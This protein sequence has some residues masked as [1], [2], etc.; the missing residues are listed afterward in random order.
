M[1]TEDYENKL[2]DRI[3]ELRMQRGVAEYRMSLELGKSG[4]YIRNITSGTAMPSVR[5]LF[6]I[7]EYLGITPAEFFAPFAEEESEYEKTVE[8][9]RSV[10]GENLAKVAQMIEWIDK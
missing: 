7:I 10:R 1:S 3:T 4:S 2:R 6:S 9:I 8:R 5:E